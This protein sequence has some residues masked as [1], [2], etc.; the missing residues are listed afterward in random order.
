MYTRMNAKKGIM[1]TYR[2]PVHFGAPHSRGFTIVELLIVIVVIGILA[3]LVLNT[4]NGVQRR[5]RDSQ[6]R[7]DVNAIATNLELYYGD[8]GGY[9][10]TASMTTLTTLNPDAIKAP[11]N[12]GAVATKALSAAAT[13]DGVAATGLN[14]AS[15][16][17]VYGYWPLLVN[18]T[19]TCTTAPCAK[20]KL[21]WANEDGTVA[22]QTKNSLN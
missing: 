11:L 22:V 5:S 2:C 12:T 18:G 8:N 14:P 6:R 20:F 7:T 3:A 10:L 1:A 9:P 13:A 19:T 17:E 4:F 16:T 21:Y 15:A